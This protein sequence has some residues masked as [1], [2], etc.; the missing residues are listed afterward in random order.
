ME[1]YKRD[2]NFRSRLCSPLLANSLTFLA[3]QAYTAVDVRAAP[4]GL[5]F[6]EQA[7]SLYRAEAAVDTIPNVAATAILA[8]ASIAAGKD[9]F[10]QE[11]YNSGRIL[12]ERLGLFV[13]PP[14]DPL[15]VSIR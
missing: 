5:C 2:Y 13:V 15:A 4:L 1:V 10:G 8:T 3:C 7:E 12:G 9:A 11:L 6:F 14:N